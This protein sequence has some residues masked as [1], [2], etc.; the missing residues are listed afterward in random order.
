MSYYR[1]RLLIDLQYERNND[2]C[3]TNAMRNRLRG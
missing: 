3:L 1:L 2:I